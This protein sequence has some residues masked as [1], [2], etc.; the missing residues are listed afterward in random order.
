MLSQLAFSVRLRLSCISRVEYLQ[1]SDVSA[2]IIITILRYW[3][4][5][6]GHVMQGTEWPDREAHESSPQPHTLLL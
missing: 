2:N 6:L 3:L 4:V 1:L 5:V